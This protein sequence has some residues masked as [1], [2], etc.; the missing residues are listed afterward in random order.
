MNGNGWLKTLSVT[1]AGIVLA[2][3][4]VG[5]GATS[6][7]T[8]VNQRGLEV[9]VENVTADVDANTTRTEGIDVMQKQVDI[10]ERDVGKI[11]EKLDK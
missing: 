7:A 10:I 4:I 6:I 9:K 11:L 2:A 1:V 3:V 8:S 5:A